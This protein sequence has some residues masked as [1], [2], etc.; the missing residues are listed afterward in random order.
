MNDQPGRTTTM[1]DTKNY[2]QYRN[3]YGKLVTDR[4]PSEGQVNLIAKLLAEKTVPTEGYIAGLIAAFQADDLSGQNART[5][6]DHLIAAKS[7]VV[8]P[9]TLGPQ[10]AGKP[11]SEKQLTWVQKLRN[12]KAVPEAEDEVIGGFLGEGLTGRHA[13][14]LL[15]Y[16]FSLPAFDAPAPAQGYVGQLGEDIEVEGTLS[17]FRKIPSKFGETNLIVVT[18]DDGRQVKSFSNAK[19]FWGLE[20][21]QRITIRGEVRSHETY[22]GSEATVLKRPQALLDM[23]A[24]DPTGEPPVAAADAAPAPEKGEDILGFW[25]LDS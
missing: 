17:T 4:G 5:L 19:S 15:D 3:Q 6:I 9:S 23:P 25:G 22:H 21:G 12:E 10:E 2:G 1:N 24:F 8:A 16:L 18:L 7:P 20:E 14:R 11:A 13:G